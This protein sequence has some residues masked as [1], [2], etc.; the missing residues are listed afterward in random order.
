MKST[1]VAAA[2]M[3]HQGHWWAKLSVLVSIGQQP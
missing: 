2:T 1:Q 3:Q